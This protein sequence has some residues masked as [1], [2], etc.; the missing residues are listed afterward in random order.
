MKIKNI[1]G[2]L[3]VLLF[4]IPALAQ[5]NTNSNDIYY[6][7]G[8]VG[9][10]VSNPDYPL[11]V[12][13]SGIAFQAV[14]EGAI[15]MGEAYLS[16]APMSGSGSN[17][18]NISTNA[19]FNNSVGP[20]PPN[21]LGWTYP[22]NMPGSLIQLEND[23]VR[24]YTHNGGAS[25]RS[26]TETMRIN[27]DGLKVR[28]G[29]LE[30]EDGG[31]T[32]KE[33]DIIIK[34][35]TNTNDIGDLIFKPYDATDNDQ[36]QHGRIWT[37]NGTVVKRLYLSSD[38][39]SPDITINEGGNVGIGTDNPSILS[40]SKLQV[41]G[42][43]RMLSSP[44]P[45]NTSYHAG[46]MRWTGADFEGY[47][48]SQWKSFTSGSSG[49]DNLGNH[50]ATGN[51]TLGNHWLS[52]DGG[53][54]GIIVS[55]TGRVT[56][57]LNSSEN[58]SLNVDQTGAIKLGKAY[59]SYLDDAG[60]DFAMLS[61][62]AWYGKGQW[63]FQGGSGSAVQLENNEIRFYTHNG[64]S[65]SNPFSETMVM[66]ADGNMGIGITTPT[67]KLEINGGL[68][69]ANSTGNTAGIIRWTGTDFEGYTGSEWKSFTSGTGGASSPWTSTG[70]TIY[71]T[72]T[73]GR[74]GIGTTVPDNNAQ[75]HVSGDG[76]Y[77]LVLE[78]QSSNPDITF[79]VGGI[80]RS[81]I[82]FDRIEDGLAFIHG[83]PAT[84]YATMF[85]TGGKV[86]IGTTAPQH[87]L[88]IVG[89]IRACR[90]EINNVSNWCDYVFEPDYELPSLEEV[91]SYIN[92]HKHLKDIPSE[93]EVMEHGISL[94]DMTK[95]LLKKVEELTLYMI[96]KDKEN[97]QLKSQH[98]EFNKQ[99]ASLLQRI[100]ELENN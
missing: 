79:K 82:K 15:R 90:V 51:I 66:T 35:R 87:A 45:P 69:V 1:A 24:F 44:P 37:Q 22:G 40:S 13:G 12:A 97:K 71:A 54:E 4:S 64:G 23:E 11:S 38:D 57:G 29:H 25:N 49:G 27:N 18:L 96:E 17:I 84:E 5:W 28:E 2:S 7:S 67:E 95:G 72:N 70:N 3:M 36:N 32:V 47:D 68:R 34:A 16:T 78:S 75:L 39:S 98:N 53:S 55:N 93:A 41:V 8:N 88:D 56:I 83:D 80:V 6:N 74:I 21:P 77:Q 60:N 20:I 10:G 33:G 48:G 42:S 65:G 30:V 52:G 99:V 94:D 76:S 85:M 86:G 59:L 61:T 100:E 43:I 62:R 73:N 9:I 63:H 50:I 92:T 89:T 26:F 19:W 46:A 14:N 58:I 31:I 81:Q 91:E